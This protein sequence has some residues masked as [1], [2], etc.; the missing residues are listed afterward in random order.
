[1]MSVSRSILLAA[2]LLAFST[3]GAWAQ[4]PANDTVSKTTPAR[5]GET[6]SGPAGPAAVP[7]T[8]KSTGEKIDSGPHVDAG[9]PSE[10]QPD[11]N[12]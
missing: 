3:A 12:K 2:I 8:T 4:P 5:P 11:A 9:R 1:M 6:P 7:T 10:K